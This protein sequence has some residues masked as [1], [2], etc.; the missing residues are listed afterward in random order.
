VRRI[1]L[2]ALAALLPTS[3]WAQVRAGAAAQGGPGLFA[4]PLPVMSS[5]AAGDGPSVPASAPEDGRSSECLEKS[6]DP[7]SALFR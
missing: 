1:A 3:G 5:P 4:A 2:I 7:Y 6:F